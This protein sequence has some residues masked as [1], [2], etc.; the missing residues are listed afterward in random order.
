MPFVTEEKGQTLQLRCG[1]GPEQVLEFSPG[2]LA[3]RIVDLPLAGVQADGHAQ[4]RLVIGHTFVPSKLGMGPDLRALGVMIRQIELLTDAV[5]DLLPL[6]AGNSINLS[7]PEVDHMVRLAG[8]SEPDPDGRWTDGT[9]ATIDLKLAP[10]SIEMGRLRLHVM[11]FVTEEKGQ[12]L[13]LRCG[14]GQERAVEFAPGAFAWETVDLPLADVRADGLTRIYIAV[15]HTFL[16]SKL[17]ISADARALGVMIRQIEL[18]SDTVPDLACAQTEESTTSSSLV[19]EDLVPLAVGTSISLASPDAERTIRLTGFS[20][21]E[22]DGRW[23]D[24]STATIAVRLGAH[25]RKGHLRIYFTP[26]VTSHT[27]Q[28]IRVKCGDG[29]ELIRR[30]SAGPRRQT[31][32]DLPLNRVE[33]NGEIS[34]SIKID[35]PNSPASVGLGADERR[36]GIQLHRLEFV[37]G[38]SRFTSTGRRALRRLITPLRPVLLKSRDFF[39][40]PLVERL[41]QLDNQIRQHG[42]AVHAMTTDSFARVERLVTERLNALQTE[43]AHLSNEGFATQ[44]TQI[45]A[46]QAEL[47]RLTDEGFA[48]QVTQLNALRAELAQVTNEGLVKQGAQVDAVLRAIKELPSRE[49]FLAAGTRL[50]S[51]EQALVRVE[52]LTAKLHEKVDIVAN[53]FLLP[54]DDDTVLVR[55]FVGYLYCSRDDHAVL[56]GLIEGGEFEP[57]LRRLLDR[58]LEPGMVFLDVGAHLGLHTLTAARRV[59]HSGQ[60]FF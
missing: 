27:G 17:G 56:T 31:L 52:Q 18:L 41:G 16:P 32:L 8:F 43:V 25:A 20:G 7:S 33:P 58:V 10:E 39:A 15:G 3:W 1:E 40:H 45:N 30:Y 44:A 36:L 2:T 37:A 48:K 26:F 46:L 5:E 57:G 60:Y 38:F 21:L 24:G 51:L 28:S 19:A 47:E 22:S 55:S 4:I 53:R 42:D 49:E 11:P 34:I 12:T 50:G 59:G 6:A 14:H 9:V 23:T 13:Q 54:V 29:P 35:A